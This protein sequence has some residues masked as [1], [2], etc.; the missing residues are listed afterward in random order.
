VAE[1]LMWDR[2]R[3]RSHGFKF[4]R[5]H[6][7]GPYRLDFY[8]HDARLAVEMDGEQHDPI[9]DAARDAYMESL[10]IVTHRIPNLRFFNFDAESVQD[11]VEVIIA[12]C[13]QRVRERSQKSKDLD[14]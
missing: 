14:S 8:C 10:G 13:E 1:Q 11:E 7:L 3:N 12:L 9:R 5:E 2:L 4:R 6:P